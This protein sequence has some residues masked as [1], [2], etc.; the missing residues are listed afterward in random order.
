MLL[1]TQA[2]VRPELTTAVYAIRLGAKGQR[3]KAEVRA[4]HAIRT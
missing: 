3:P 4:A 1:E 2:G